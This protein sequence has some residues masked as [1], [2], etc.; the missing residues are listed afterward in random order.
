LSRYFLLGVVALVGP[1]AAC[2]GS[3][4]EPIVDGGDGGEKEVTDDGGVPDG[5][6]DA[7]D[8]SDAG[9]ILF[10][11]GD[12]AIPDGAIPDVNIPDVVGA[13]VACTAESLVGSWEAVGVTGGLSAVTLTFKSDGTF[14]AGLFVPAPTAGD[15][16]EDEEIGTYTVSDA[17]LNL[18]PTEVTC[19]VPFG[20]GISLCYMAD[21]DFFSLNTSGQVTAIWEPHTSTLPPSA[22]TTGCSVNGGPFIPYSLMPVP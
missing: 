18:A 14:T 5:S 12:G 4:P 19:S 17:L 9:P 16:Y 2:G 13:I 8:G 22:I 3:K 11:S 20:S 21:G 6:K 10:G 15:F 7:S 1:L